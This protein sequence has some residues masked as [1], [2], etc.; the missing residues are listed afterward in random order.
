L[1]LFVPSNGCELAYDLQ[2]ASCEKL[3][4][5]LVA[6]AVSPKDC[7]SARDC[8]ATH[9]PSS[10]G[11]IGNLTPPGPR[12]PT[13]RGRTASRTRK[14]TPNARNRRTAPLSA[15]TR[16]PVWVVEPPDIEGI[17]DTSGE[18]NQSKKNATIELWNEGVCKDPARVPWVERDGMYST[19]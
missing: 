11:A 1:Y 4:V 6:F 3:T 16:Y 12:I 14:R 18:S 10:L 9:A 19:S 17:Q 5:L 15:R 8:S 13:I 7:K 2:V